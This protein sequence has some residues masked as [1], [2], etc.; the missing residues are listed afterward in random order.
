MFYT[1]CGVVCVE[2]ANFCHK[3]G[4][5]IDV[6][7]DN[8]ENN[9]DNIDNIIEGYFYRGYRYRDIVS[10]LAKHYGVQIHVRTLKR[11]LKDL[12]LKRRQTDFDEETVRLCIEKEIQ[13][14]GLLAGYRYIWHA[15]RLRHHLIVPRGVVSDIMKEIDQDGVRERKVRRL[16][17]RTYVSFGPNFARHI[18]GM[19]IIRCYNRVNTSELYNY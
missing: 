13:E 2:E 8:F 19:Y 16:R 7:V 15:L 12:G 14:A 4:S 6:A 17:R 1:S 10:L 18:D 3:C 11:K 5:R 9:R